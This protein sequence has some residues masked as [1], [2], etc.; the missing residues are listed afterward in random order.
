MEAVEGLLILILLTNPVAQED[1]E[2]FSKR[3]K[4]YAN[5]PVSIEVG[6]PANNKLTTMVG[7]TPNDLLAAGNIGKTL[8]KQKNVIIIHFDK[9]TVSGDKLLDAQLWY[10]G[11][12]D[13]YVSIAGKD[14]NP[15]PGL[16]EGCTSMIGHKLR[17]QDGASAMNPGTSKNVSLAHLAKGKAWQQLLGKVAAIK[18]EERAPIVLYYQIMAYVNLG[19]RDFAVKVLNEFR[20]KYKGHIL[21]S[22]AEAIIPPR[23]RTDEELMDLGNNNIIDPLFEGDD[24]GKLKDKPKKKEVINKIP[25]DA[26]IEKLYKELLEKEAKAAEAAKKKAAQAEKDVEAKD[27]KAKAETVPTL[28]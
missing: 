26:N 1:A 20:E 17:K 14:G 24:D 15:L 19:Q 13:S 25:K 3:L 9:R 27:S 10:D 6:K 23:E 4:K 22:S 12:Q 11:R 5:Q 21:V 16:V 8:T 28:K 18:P 2:S 7:I